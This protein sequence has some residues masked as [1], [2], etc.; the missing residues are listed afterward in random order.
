[1]YREKE[2]H[3]EG[4][5]VSGSAR[6]WFCRLVSAIGCVLLAV[7]AGFV[8]W[9]CY[10]ILSDCGTLSVLEAVV[11]LVKGGVIFALIVGIVFVVVNTVWTVN[12]YGWRGLWDGSACGSRKKAQN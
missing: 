2:E 9:L 5:E 8:L 7:I 11:R 12:L 6:L 3:E 4:E 1:M 10:Y